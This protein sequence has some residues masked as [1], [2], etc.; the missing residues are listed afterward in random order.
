MSLHLQPTDF[1][2]LTD[3]ISAVLANQLDVNGKLRLGIGRMTLE[4]LPDDYR[5]LGNLMGHAAAQLPFTPV[6]LLEPGFQPLLLNTK[7]CL[8]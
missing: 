2:G 7:Q 4:L 5:P 8:N 1:L 3:T 6:P